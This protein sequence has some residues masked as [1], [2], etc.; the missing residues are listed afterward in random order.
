MTDLDAHWAVLIERR[1]GDVAAWTGEGTVELAVPRRSAGE[2]S[3]LTRLQAGTDLQ[4][5]G[6]EF[7][8]GS[9]FAGAGV[10]GLGRSYLID[11]AT[12]GATQIRTH[13]TL[14]P[15]TVFEVDGEMYLIGGV[16]TMYRWSPAARTFVQRGF[17]GG[18]PGGARTGF[19][20]GDWVYMW[21]SDQP[22]SPGNVGPGRWH[23][24]GK[25]AF[26]ANVDLSGNFTAGAA[27]SPTTF[28][29][30]GSSRLASGQVVTMGVIPDGRIRFY[31]AT[32]GPSGM[33]TETIWTVA[34]PLAGGN[35]NQWRSFAIDPDTGF[36]LLGA[37]GS[38]IY[39]V[40]APG[41]TVYGE[42]FS[43][44]L[45]L[46]DVQP[47]SAAL[48]AGTAS[49]RV[50]IADPNRKWREAQGPAP[51]TV[52]Q[53]AR[54]AGG[55]WEASALAWRGVVGSAT[56]SDGLWTATVTP[57]AQAAVHQARA[58]VWSGQAQL[59]RTD[60]ADSGLLRMDGGRPPLR[61]P[62]SL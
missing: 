3:L 35:V 59:E 45:G 51:V 9:L 53:V 27:W 5:R 23:R 31:R 49:W 38:R 8:L 14:L 44:G 42:R 17:I 56:W 19:A 52:W 55:G 28:T 40:A 61:I 62:S 33:Q 50:R 1:D 32:P 36:G 16:G 4:I 54:R 20:A 22:G 37:F 15:R 2:I 41:W 13:G 6:M 29:Q 39:R 57:V 43:S 24:I 60:G 58:V 46:V 11:L 48:A 47:P 7:G 25:A 12:R 10:G 34:R 18:M 30:Q 26:K 21:T